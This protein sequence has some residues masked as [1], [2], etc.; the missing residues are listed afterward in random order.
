MSFNINVL[1][2]RKV[3]RILSRLFDSVTMDG[4]Y[5]FLKKVCLTLSSGILRMLLVLYVLLTVEIFLNRY[6]GDLFSVSFRN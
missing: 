6:V 5:E 4:K 2:D 1:K 3:F